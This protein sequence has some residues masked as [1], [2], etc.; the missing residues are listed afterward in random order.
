MVLVNLTFCRKCDDTN[1]FEGSVE[2]E[3]NIP[4]KDAQR[5]YF[6]Q[7]IRSVHPD[8]VG[9]NNPKIALLIWSLLLL[10]LLLFPIDF[11]L[12]IF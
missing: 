1:C 2:T 7:L 9:P 4:I 8:I 11:I 6:Y 3:R 12:M 10:S 5:A